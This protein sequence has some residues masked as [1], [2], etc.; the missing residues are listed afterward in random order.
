MAPAG[1]LLAAAERLYTQVLE[2]GARRWGTRI[3]R[4]PWAKVEVKTHLKRRY[5]EDEQRLLS[6]LAGEG[7]TTC[8]I[9]RDL[10]LSR[11]TIKMA[12]KALDSCRKQQMIFASLSCG[13]FFKYYGKEGE[14]LR[15]H[16][17]LCQ[18]VNSLE[19]PQSHLS[20]LV[21]DTKEEEEL[22]SDLQ[23][24]TPLVP[25]KSRLLPIPLE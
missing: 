15:V 10:G 25:P 12:L 24:L 6:L 1:I 13:A 14:L 19:Q 5:Q 22:A 9:H 2:Q 17:P 23:S 16:C 18:E 7:S 11:M 8:R 21:P 4:L 3:A 20:L